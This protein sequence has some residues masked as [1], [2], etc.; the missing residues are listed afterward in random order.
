MGGSELQV[1]GDKWRCMFE[2]CGQCEDNTDMTKPGWRSG[3]QAGA[4]Y[5]DGSAF[6]ETG[7]LQEP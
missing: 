6:I 3:S 2:V 5:A 4:E 1:G 7:N